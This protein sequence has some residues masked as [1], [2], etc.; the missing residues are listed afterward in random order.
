MVHIDTKKLGR[1]KR[2]GKRIPGSSRTPLR[3]GCEFLFV[4]VDD[5]S[6][7]SF[8]DLY[9]DERKPSAI[10]KRSASS[11][12]VCSPLIAASATFDLNSS[13]W[14]RRAR[15]IAPA[16]RACAQLEQSCIY[17]G[18]QKSGALSSCA[19]EDKGAQ[20]TTAKLKTLINFMRNSH[21]LLRLV[22]QR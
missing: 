1:I 8:T 12:S 14:L 3:A 16:V 9:P 15:F 2:M 11:A 6:R 20:T 10:Q 21:R 13:E 22:T 17:P 18:V 4:A 5:H 19:C 7:I